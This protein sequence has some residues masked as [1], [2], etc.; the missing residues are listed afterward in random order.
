MLIFY[1]AVMKLTWCN[2]VENSMSVLYPMYYAF[3]PVNFVESQ[4][5]GSSSTSSN[6][7]TKDMIYWFKKFKLTRSTLNGFQNSETYGQR[8]VLQ[9]TIVCAAT[10]DAKRRGS[11]TK[12]W[13]AILIASIIKFDLK[14]IKKK[15][16]GLILD[17][18]INKLQIHQIRLLCT[19]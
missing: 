2:W 18:W 1:Q 14:R 19:I 4:W 5:N 3:E 7:S 12:N 15:L 16:I 8:K 17:V 9:E 13:V 6:S 10:T 11:S